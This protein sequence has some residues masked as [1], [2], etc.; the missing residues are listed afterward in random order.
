MAKAEA[1]N[2]PVP[3]PTNTTEETKPKTAAAPKVVEVEREILPIQTKFFGLDTHQTKRFCAQAATGTKPEDLEKP[4]FWK[5]V[6]VQLQMGYEVRVLAEDYS[7]VAY[8]IVTFKH[9]N[10]VKVS[11]HNFKELDK[12]SLDT[13]G[14]SSRYIAKQRGMLKWCIVDTETGE[15]VFENIPNQGKALL[16]LEQYQATLL[17]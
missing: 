12:V 9:A 8:G 2:V 3:P 11:I 14:I 17:R 4:E 15:N 10:N 6:A 5:H 13:Q 7:W 16:E 1:K